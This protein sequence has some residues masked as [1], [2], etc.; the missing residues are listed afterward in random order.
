MRLAARLI[1]ICG[2]ALGSSVLLLLRAWAALLAATKTGRILRAVSIPRMQEHKLRTSLTVLGITLGIALLVAVITVNKSIMEGVNATVSDIAGRADLEI[3]AGTSGFDEQ[4]LAVVKST[5]GVAKSSPVIQ[6]IATIEDPRAQGERL[7][8]VGVD[9]LS[10][11]DAYF[12]E[13]QS[14]GL[15]EI[16]S[17]PIPFLNSPHA[18]LISRRLAERLGRKLHDKLAIATGTGIKHFEIWGILDETGTGVGHAFGGAVAVMYHAAMST[19]FGRGR[20]IDRI[21]VAVAPGTQLDEVK[22]RLTGALGDA[23]AIE[24]P[25]GK[26]QRIGRMLIGVQKALLMASLIALLVAAFLIHNTLTISVVQ[27]KRELGTLRA[28][29][30]RRAELRRVLTLEGAV[31]GLTGSVLGILLGL[32]LA[33]ALLFVTSTALNEA[34][35]QLAATELQVDPIVL[36]ASGASGVMFASLAAAL[37]AFQASK[38]DPVSSLRT[39]GIVQTGRNPRGWML[40]DAAALVL[41][42]A[43]WLVLRLPNGGFADPFAFVSAGAL[44]LAGVLLIPRLVY[45][46]DRFGRAPI[47][48]HLGLEAR[49]AQSNL[50]RDVGRTTTTAG[51]LLVGVAMAGAFAMFIG[52]VT[53]AMYQWVDQTMAGDLFVTNAASMTGLS[54]KEIPMSDSLYPELLALP[55]VEDVRRLSVH[56]VPFRGYP[57]KLASTDVD[58]FMKHSKVSV[59]E[60]SVDDVV[61][62]WKNGELVISENLATRFDLHQ[63]DSV[64]LGVRDGSRKF[65]VAA[66]IVD[67]TS[68]MG[69]MTLDR[70][71]YVKAYGDSRV[72]TYE[73]HLRPGADAIK[74][75]HTIHARYGAGYNLFVLTHQ[76]LHDSIRGRVDQVFTLLRALELVALLVAMLGVVNAQLANVIDRVREIGVLRAVGMLRRQ[77]ARMILFEA[78]FIGATGALLG[79]IVSMVLGNIILWYINIAATGWHFPSHVPVLALV[80]IFVLTVLAAGGAGFYPGRQAAELSIPDALEYE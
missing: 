48:R 70:E 76:E 61:R 12:R 47:A 69:S 38:S 13:Y 71:T 34:Y 64:T 51:A 1:K 10:E 36:I 40:S 46:I 17:D 60:G 22:A 9:L 39:T 73:I 55:E 68:D 14:T 54:L 44:L 20:N 11:D 28:L 53:S 27:R 77:V 3:S 7:L 24:R 41:L 29:G 75:R 2:E 67:Y 35:L 59:L 42:A 21:D 8:V 58:T 6:Q 30:S 43:S 16:L 26:G 65:R 33:R 80:E 74:V 79:L 52:S 23:F 15:H 50:P 57:V 19:A 37:A 72:S 31:F 32:A 63:G 45:A 5:A 62:G 66:V 4:L 18:I 78:F 49:L 56:E 25:A